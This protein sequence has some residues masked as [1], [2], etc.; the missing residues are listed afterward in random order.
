MQPSKFA[1]SLGNCWGFC[2]EK[3]VFSLMWSANY[4]WGEIVSTIFILIY[5]K[6]I[7]KSK[8]NLHFYTLSE[9]TLII[10]MINNKRWSVDKTLFG[11]KESAEAAIQRF[12]LYIW[13]FEKLCQ[14]SGKYLCWSLFL[15]KFQ[16]LRSATLFKSD[17]IKSVFLWILRSF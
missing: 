2:G 6:V 4:S 8:K 14:F 9:Q 3:S 10:T 15:M 5:E 11:T 7:V 12:F 13:F 17:S 1:S 16:A